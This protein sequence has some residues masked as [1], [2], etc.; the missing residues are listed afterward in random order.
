M[1]TSLTNWDACPENTSTSIWRNFIVLTIGVLFGL[2]AQAQSSTISEC[3]LFDAG[4]NATWTHVITLT[5]ADDPSSADAQ[6]LSINVAGL[7]EAG[8]NYRVVKTVANGNWFQASA[9]PLIP[10]DNSITVG[11]VSFARSVKIQFSSGDVEFDGLVINGEEQDACYAVTAD[12]GT[13]IA[14]CNLFAP[15]PNETWTHALTATT[16]DDPNSSAA[17]TLVLNVASLPEGG[18]NYRVAKTVANGNWFNGNA[19]ALALGENSITVSAV[20]FARSV[21]FQF[22]SGDVL[23]LIHI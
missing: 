16:P 21:K 1:L 2:S 6:T 11:G 5:A 23:S 13:P 7:P 10:G 15:G 8:A 18:A 19:Q 20:A 9:Q 3:S 22:S 12:P 14:D 17:Q 4:P